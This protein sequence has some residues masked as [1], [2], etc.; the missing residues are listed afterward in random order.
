[1]RNPKLL[2]E[3]FLRFKSVEKI[4]CAS[5]VNRNNHHCCRIIYL[6]RKLLGAAKKIFYINRLDKLYA[7]MRIFGFY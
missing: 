3:L 7:S 2:I 4:V 5:I 6:A 1:M